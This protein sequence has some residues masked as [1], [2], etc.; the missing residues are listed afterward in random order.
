MMNPNELRPVDADE[1]RSRGI[2]AEHNQMP[3]GEYRFRL[4]SRDGSAYI[5][6]EATADSG[7]QRSHWH[8]NVKETFIVQQGRMALAEWVSDSLHLRIFSAGEIV[9]TQPGISHNVYMFPDSIIH[10]VKHGD[11]GATADWI[12]DLDLDGKTRS[13]T[14]TEILKL[15]N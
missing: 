4:R 10:T 5:R 15:A 13:L 7:W 3:N 12:A 6:T 1:A 14:E 9:T 2:W 11:E 8:R